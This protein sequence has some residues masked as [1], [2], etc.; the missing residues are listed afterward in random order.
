MVVLR[1]NQT[2]FIFKCRNCGFQ[3][4]ERPIQQYPSFAEFVM[5]CPTCHSGN[6]SEKIG[7]R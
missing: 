3:T 7:E 4:I 6:I 1:M 2:Y 5:H